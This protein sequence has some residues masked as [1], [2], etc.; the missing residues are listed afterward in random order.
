MEVHARGN[1]IK[2]RFMSFSFE[3]TPR[4]SLGCKLV[5]VRCREI[6]IVLFAEEKTLRGSAAAK[7]YVVNHLSCLSFVQ[8]F[9]IPSKQCSALKTKIQIQTVYHFASKSKI[10]IRKTRHSF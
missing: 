10:K 7:C 8:E 3:K 9:I 6:R 4:I 2:K 5:P 1:V